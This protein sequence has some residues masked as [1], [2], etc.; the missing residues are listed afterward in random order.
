MAEITSPSGRVYQWNK[1]TPPTKDDIDALVAYDSSVGGTP[2]TPSQ[3][4]APVA[5]PGPDAQLQSAVNKS[6]SVGEMRRREGEGEIAARRDRTLLETLSAASPVNMSPLGVG[7]VPPISQSDIQANA[8]AAREIAPIVAGMAAPELLPAKV[9]L[10]AAAGKI[11]PKLLSSVGIGT[12]SGVA[13]QATEEAVSGFQPAQKGEFGPLGRI[14]ESAGLGGLLGATGA[15][16][17]R[18]GPT[19]YQ[20]AKN[21]LSPRKAL[22]TA[23]RPFGNASVSQLEA[24]A[25]RQTIQDTTGID[26]PV[27]V[28]EAIGTP[29]L[30]NEIKNIQSG[31]ELSSEAKDAI[32]RQ[33]AFSATQLKN[34]F[35]TEEDLAKHTIATLRQQI[36]DL[37]KPVNDAIEAASKELHPAIQS[38]FKQVQNDAL[39][40]VP[41]TSATPT[42]FGVKVRSEIQ[43]TFSDLS[44]GERTAFQKVTSNP[45]YKAVDIPTTETKAWRNALQGSTVQTASG[46]IPISITPQGTGK[47][48]S[49][50]PEFEDVQTLEGMR[51]FRT[52]V[53]GSIGNDTIF[54][55]VSDYQKKQLY[56]AVSQDIE[57][58]IASLPGSTLKTDLQQANS[59]TKQKYSTFDNPMMDKILK[60]FGPEGGIGP[61][62]LAAKLRS[63]DGPSFL[64]ELKKS[65]PPARA[66]A[67]TDATSEYLFND[68]GNAA[69]N[70]I[71]GEISAGQLLNGIDSL[72]PEIRAEFFP[73]YKNIVDLAKK[74]NALSKVDPKKI[75]SNLSVDDPALLFD[76]LGAAPSKDVTDKIVNAFAKSQKLQKQYNG[77]VIG[78][79]KEMDGDGLSAIIEQ[80]PSKF[81]RSIMD[82]ET[83][84]PA[85]TE[86][87]MR[88]IAT[89]NPKLI[90]DLQFNFINDLLSRSTG[91]GRISANNLLKEIL[92]ESPLGKA[93]S[94]RGISEA[95]LGPNKL[96]TLES[97]LRNLSAIEKAG[98]DLSPNSPLMDLVA[99][100][101]GAA[102]GAATRGMTGIGTIGA[103]NELASIAGRS[104]KIKYAIASYILT[105]PELR[106]LAITPINRIDPTTAKN[107]INGF[108]NYMIDRFGPDSPE[109][110]EIH[111]M[112]IDANRRSAK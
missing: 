6:A 72:A 12:V 98:G 36:G 39:A 32:K 61:A 24:S 80:N 58:G 7:F 10:T 101:V 9:A 16:I 45:D 37:S 41:G 75:I 53:G 22:T 73:N 74:Q 33:V 3:P 99:R 94:M 112:N 4:S 29:Q 23:Y 63:A 44:A 19:A 91:Q 34:T 96:D 15:A 77:T 28:G 21:V 92:P 87:A 20:Y 5:Q 8:A 76:A 56:K 47:F 89:H 59:L 65:V 110:D 18:F 35:V 100:G 79:L 13:Q 68:I 60:D 90:N 50:I 88:I 31:L 81:M 78:A 1:P 85:Q 30:A 69:R 93:G 57:A 43:G 70:S 67:I 62:S 66:K 54:P 102:A 82:G 83:F 51:N 71:S 40:L 97:T 48:A 104:Q 17:E 25:A 105:T 11:V 95:V 52:Q 86:K 2:S 55:G 49:I 84:S 108:S 111:T 106:K 42:S 64:A 103:A 109:A 27:G 14:V 26:V 38:A 107:V 46:N